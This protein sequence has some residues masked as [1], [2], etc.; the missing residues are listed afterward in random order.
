[1]K[2]TSHII[3]SML[4]IG[5]LLAIPASASQNKPE[6]TPDNQVN[7]RMPMGSGQPFCAWQRGGED[8][9]A[10]LG[11][12]DEQ[13]EKLVSLRNQFK[14]NSFSVKHELSSNIRKLADLL[15]QPKVDRQEIMTVQDKINSLRT[16]LSNARLAFLMDA[17]DVL[18][19]DQKKLVRHKM[20]IHQLMG[21][22]GGPGRHG[23]HGFPGRPG[24]GGHPGPGCP[25]D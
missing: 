14:D 18:T 23:H 5:S 17:S 1:M 21:F 8:C 19:A 15:S 25:D 22:A 7:T 9:F 10:S 20:L 13:L 16:N 24:F 3:T 4:L 6:Q 11:V 2:F 12:T